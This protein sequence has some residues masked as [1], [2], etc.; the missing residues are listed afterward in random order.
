MYR[1]RI[2]QHAEE[3]LEQ[4]VHQD[5][6]GGAFLLN[7]LDEIQGDQ[8]LL[9]RL[10][11]RGYDV[12]NGPDWAANLN[13]SFFEEQQQLNRN[14]WRLKTWELEA[15]R[16]RVVYAFQPLTKTYVV[17]GVFHRGNF[18]YEQDNPFT[19]RVVADY[20]DL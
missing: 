5:L 14:I 13:V 1:L 17:L 4:I 8:N 2:H 16:Y 20:E 10:S 18:N 3:D 6:D 11:Q 15:S 7:L 19:Q 12:R 9:D